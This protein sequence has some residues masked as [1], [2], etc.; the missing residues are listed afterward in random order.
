MS[1]RTKLILLGTLLA[2]LGVV[3]YFQLSRKE[4]ARGESASAPPA[5]SAQAT[6][7]EPADPAE[8]KP[9][10]PAQASSGPTAVDLRELAEWFDVLRPAGTV[11]ARGSA[12]VF[13]ITLKPALPI[14]RAPSQE[15]AQL[16]PWMTEP[17]KL[18]GIVKAGN[19]P[20]KALFQGE[21]YQV[22]DIVRGTNFTLAAVE[23][24]FVTLKSGDR[25]IRRFWHE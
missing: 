17:G 8:A 21:L 24:D 4:P 1:P 12:P 25:V 15:P 18:D 19:G 14:P 6:A 9:A 2:L 5:R 11:I 13:G 7:S 16:I 10:D 22:G 23:D 20:G 3:A